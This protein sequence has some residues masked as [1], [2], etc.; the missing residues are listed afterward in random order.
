MWKCTRCKLVN[1]VTYDLCANCGADQHG[2]QDLI[3]SRL[4][5]WRRA[6]LR[7]VM[8]LSIVYGPSYFLLGS[9]ACGSDLHRSSGKIREYT[10]HERGFPF[11]PWIYKPLARIEYSLRGEN[12]QIVIEDNSYRG[13][14][15]IY[16]YGPFK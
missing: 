2:K 1:D 7:L 9:H 10:Y 6:V 5:W 8:L 16:T 3:L 12:S 13:G 14:Q 15:P 4:F 11:D